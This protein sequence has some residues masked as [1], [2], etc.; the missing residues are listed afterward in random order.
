MA[1]LAKVYSRARLERD[2]AVLPALEMRR[3]LESLRNKV[4]SLDQAYASL[5]INIST[6]IKSLLEE[7]ANSLAAHMAIEQDI[8][9]PAVHEA[10]ESLT[11]ESFEEH[12]VAQ[13]ELK[14]L[15]AAEPDDPMFLAKVTTLKELILHHVK[16]EEEDLF[17]KVDKLFNAAELETMGKNMAQVFDKKKE[18]VYGALLLKGSKTPA[19][20][21][22]KRMLSSRPQAAE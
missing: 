1:W 9:Y 11:L 6:Q 19:D 22:S 7:L 12:A 10:D 2:Q 18:E 15:L 17:P 8:F 16:E 20:L 3:Q 13:L 5:C 4:D 14:R 21:A